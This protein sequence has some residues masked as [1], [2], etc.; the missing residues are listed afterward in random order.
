MSDG[1]S[2]PQV[3]DAPT[4]SPWEFQMRILF[5]TT[6]G[7]G[8]FGALIPFAKAAVAGHS[9][10]MVAAPASF[11]D[12]VVG[13]GLPLW[14]LGEPTREEWGSVMGRVAGLSEEAGDQLVVGEI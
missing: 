2:R 12:A 8:H 4:Q 6:A 10:V 13:A 1:H 7:A 5:A 14:G 9:E 3:R 11:R